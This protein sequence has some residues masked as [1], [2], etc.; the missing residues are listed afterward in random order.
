MFRSGRMNLETVRKF[1]NSHLTTGCV[2]SLPLNVSAS[3]EDQTL[4]VWPRP[5]GVDAPRDPRSERRTVCRS[6]FKLV[7]NAIIVSPSPRRGLGETASKFSTQLQ[8]AAADGLQKP[9]ALSGPCGLQE[10]KTAPMPG[11]FGLEETRTRSYWSRF[12]HHVKERGFA[13]R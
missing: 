5:P 4:K 2:S 6:D 1:G 9:A 8:S 3:Q 13:P 11:P 12:P 7:E 10:T